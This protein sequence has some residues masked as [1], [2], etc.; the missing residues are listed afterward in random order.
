MLPLALAL[1]CA[2]LAP[3]TSI[4]L[5]L[6]FHHSTTYAARPSHSLVRRVAPK[7]PSSRPHYAST[8][9]P[10]RFHCSMAYVAR[11]PHAPTNHLARLGHSIVVVCVYCTPQRVEDRPSASSHYVPS[12][13]SICASPSCT[14][15]SACCPPLC[16]AAQSPASR[17]RAPGLRN[18][19]LCPRRTVRHSPEPNK[20]TVITPK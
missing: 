2:G 4:A 19:M 5:L 8:A 7:R 3:C 13:S 18:Q 17:D 16:I 14:H 11:L 12:L 1:H 15:N 9:L 20:G 6:C 10:L